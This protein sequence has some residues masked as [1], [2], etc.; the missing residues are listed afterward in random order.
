MKLRTILPFALLL[1]ATSVSA[2]GVKVGLR[3]G[4]NVNKIDGKSFT[5]EFRFGYHLGGAAE[6]MFSEK[7]GIQPEVLFNQS[8]PRTGYSFDTL[9]ESVNPGSLKDV[10][11]NY[12]SIPLLLNYR[13]VKFITLQA[14]P[15]FSIL[16]SKDRSLLKDGQ[17][18]F[19]NG[20]LS[21]LGGVQVSIFNF[22]VYG[23][24]GIGLANINDID[25]RDKWKSQTIQ[26]GA[27]FNF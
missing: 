10:K 22:R 9:Y 8:N 23:R 16:M 19:K 12:L 14:G 3:A 2:Q 11:L 1:A 17:E 24:Y 18:A 4:A 5:D 7:W 25:N 26:V 6:I 15:Q 21:L 27:G 20:D 13:P